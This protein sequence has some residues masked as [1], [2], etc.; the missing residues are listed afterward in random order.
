MQIADCLKK[1]S[2][3][4]GVSGNEDAAVEL[5]EKY[6]KKHVHQVRKDK[7]GNLVAYKKGRGRSSSKPRL[8]FAA[9]IDEIGLMVTRVEEG[10][11]L[12]FT[13]LGGFDPRTLYGQEVE[14]HGKKKYRGVI[15]SKP[16]HLVTR[17]DR[18]KEMKIED[19]FIDL[20]LPAE[21]VKSTV[22]IGDF[23]SVA[24]PSMNLVNPRYITGKALDNRAGVAALIYC[25]SELN[26][27]NH[28]ADV[29]FVF[30]VQEEVG[31]R[32]ALTSTYALSPHAGV[33]LDVCHGNMPGAPEKDTFELG[34]G[35]VLGFG[36][37][38]HPL[39]FEKLK[40]AA[41]K[42]HLPFQ[43]EA[44]PGPTPTDARSMQIVREGVPSGLVS[45][46][47]CPW[48]PICLAR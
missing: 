43:V 9:H 26:R 21:E 39:I 3:A 47:T 4:A 2:E 27:I 32:G 40:G 5:T 19:L 42:Y 6:I 20:A 1:L 46:R 28:A 15:G 18:K 45:P 34:K 44:S 33:A 25:A 10:G 37:N 41:E 13:T 14:V 23:V 38:I 12:R 31:A 29:Y 17:E 22:K 16:P 35:A 24:A 36:P 48:N 30:T 11:F 7:A 8:V